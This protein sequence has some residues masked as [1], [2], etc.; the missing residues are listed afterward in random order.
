M[1]EFTP[2]TN[3]VRDFYVDHRVPTYPWTRFGE[4]EIAAVESAQAEFDRWLAAHD[5]E[6]RR[7]AAEA[8]RKSDEAFPG[9]TIRD[10]VRF[11]E[12]RQELDA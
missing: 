5:A 6:V 7:A 9:M 3:A 10:A 8:I 4:D 2:E 11:L 1:S 12:G